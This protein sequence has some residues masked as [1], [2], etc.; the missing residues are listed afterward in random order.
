MIGPILGLASG[1]LGAGGDAAAPSG[2]VTQTVTTGPIAF[3]ARTFGRGA[4]S[5]ESPATATGGASIIPAAV[6]GG[7]SPVMLAVGAAA[8]LALVVFLSRRS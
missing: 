1:L 5:V 8:L 6:N 2:P 7:I 4:S 3:G